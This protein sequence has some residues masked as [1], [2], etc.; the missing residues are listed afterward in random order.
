MRSKRGRDGIFSS[1]CVECRPEYLNSVTS[2]FSLQ[3]VERVPFE[4][5]MSLLHAVTPLRFNR[6]HNIEY[7]DADCIS[8]RVNLTRF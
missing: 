3:T 4:D 5:S 1:Q 7:C 2:F 8:N 6:D